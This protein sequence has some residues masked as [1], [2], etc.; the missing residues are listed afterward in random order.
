MTDEFY[1]ILQL[2]APCAGLWDQPAELRRWGA[3]TFATTVCMPCAVRDLQPAC[4]LCVLL[5]THQP[6]WWPLQHPFPVITTV[7]AADGVLK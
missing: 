2:A 5:M 1:R 3:V 4:F 7:Q 6:A